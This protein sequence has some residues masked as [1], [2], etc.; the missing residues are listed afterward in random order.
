ML[1]SRLTVVNPLGLHARAAA[2]LVRLA[3]GFDCRVT[4][5]RIDRNAT[6]NAKS[7][8]SLLALAASAGTELDV[9]V[10]GLD[11]T[12]ALAAIDDLFRRGFGE[13]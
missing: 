9:R 8:L 12:A 5:S 10:E 7:I 6:A 11:E 13:I 3:G 2:Q 4:L 1:E